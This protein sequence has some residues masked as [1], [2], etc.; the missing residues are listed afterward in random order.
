MTNADSALAR[1]LIR[2]LCDTRPAGVADGAF[3]FAQT[4]DN[5]ESVFV[6]A[7]QL[8]DANLVRRVMFVETPP[9]SGY[10]GFRARQTALHGQGIE[11]CR[12]RALREWTRESCTR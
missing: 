8:L 10:P 6:A 3:L 4:P 9:M 1:L 12:S 5:V 2:V 7:G 11:T